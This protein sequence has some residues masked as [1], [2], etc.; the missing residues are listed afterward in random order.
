M[1][2]VINSECPGDYLPDAETPLKKSEGRGRAAGPAFGSPLRG[3][4][5][6]HC[7]SPSHCS[8]R[9]TLPHPVRVSTVPGTPNS[10]CCCPSVSPLRH[11][12]PPEQRLT[13]C[14]PCWVP[15]PLKQ[16]LARTRCSASTRCRHG[17]LTSS[18]QRAP[19]SR[20]QQLTSCS[21]LRLGA[22]A[23]RQRVRTRLPH[24]HQAS[25]CLPA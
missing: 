16:C 13:C 9:G 25:P 10:P 23:N 19:G 2:R 17:R 20:S 7:P 5:A 12:R 22:D 6:C 11:R 14:A 21:D 4:T 24:G 18:P 3:A 15:R 8:G 1:Y